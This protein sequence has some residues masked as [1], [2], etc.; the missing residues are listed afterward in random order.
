[1]F[2]YFVHN[3]DG[4]DPIAAVNAVTGAYVGAP[5]LIA[6]ASFAPAKADDILTLFATG[7]G[8]TNPSF[9]PGVLPSGQ[10]QVT[11]PVVITFGGVTLSPSDILYAGVTQDAGLYQLNLRVPKGVPD[12]DQPL[13]IRIGGVTSPSNAFITVKTPPAP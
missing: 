11:A 10:A 4:H 9:A 8:A 3:K 5:G 13:V 12:G 6:G 2:F 7:F 1:V